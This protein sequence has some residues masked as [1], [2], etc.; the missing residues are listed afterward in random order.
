VAALLN[1]HQIK[2]VDENENGLIDKADGKG[3]PCIHPE[4]AVETEFYSC[5]TG[6][7]QSTNGKKYFKLK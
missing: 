5:I 2:I 4:R 7:N 6:C 1:P 3:L